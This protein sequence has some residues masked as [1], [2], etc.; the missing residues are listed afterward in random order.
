M[1]C[2]PDFKGGLN[3][4]KFIS[5]LAAAALGMCAVPVTASA[6]AEP[7]IF[8]LKD[9]DGNV[10]EREFYG[11]DINGDG[12]TDA[13]D[14]ML[15]LSYNADLASMGGELDNINFFPFPETI[16]EY[17]DVDGD[18][19]INGLDSTLVLSYY[20]ETSGLSNEEVVAEGN[21]YLMNELPK[22]YK[23]KSLELAGEHYFPDE[24]GSMIR[25]SAG[26][27]NLDGILDARDASLILGY[28]ADLSSDAYFNDSYVHL[29]AIRVYG[30]VNQDGLINGTDASLILAYYGYASAQDA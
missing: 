9:R 18:G 20:R 8:Y 27:V 22:L 4:K 13:K 16:K 26:D 6:D 11:A 3:M 25:L 2:V 19:F 28:Y 7:Y 15:I 1:R 5:V 21:D 24:D 23:Q 10:T 30:D 14:A 17:G 29:R 12:V